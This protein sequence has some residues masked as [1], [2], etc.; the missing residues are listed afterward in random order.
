MVVVLIYTEY[1]EPNNSIQL[2]GPVHVCEHQRA[3]LDVKKTEGKILNGMLSDKE[4][5]NL[6]LNILT[7]SFCSVKEKMLL[8]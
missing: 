1:V 4:E 8:N 3:Q 7:R 6:D 2:Y 5:I